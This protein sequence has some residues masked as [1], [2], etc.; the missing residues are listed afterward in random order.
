MV[1]EKG[2]NKMVKLK[3]DL[4]AFLGSSSL[5]RTEI[6]KKLWDYSKTGKLTDFTNLKEGQTIDMMQLASVVS[7]NIE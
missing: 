3:A 1:E 5:S 2:L 4:A 6:T 7:A